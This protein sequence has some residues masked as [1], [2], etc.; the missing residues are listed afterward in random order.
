MP[1]TKLDTLKRKQV[2][3]RANGIEYKG[4]LLE[5]TEDEVTLRAQTNFISIPMNQIVSVRDANEKMG[6][7][8]D[9]QID[10]SFYDADLYKPE[11]P[12]KK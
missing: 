10:S 3:I 11:E 6:K 8:S 9:R 1:K 5:A 12:E 2:I 7:L 4:L